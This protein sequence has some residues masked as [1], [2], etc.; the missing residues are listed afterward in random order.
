MFSAQPTCYYG[1]LTLHLRFERFSKPRV[2]PTTCSQKGDIVVS[3][4][5]W[6]LNNFLY[7]T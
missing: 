3:M 1:T 6:A 4:V 2:K 5:K 7:K